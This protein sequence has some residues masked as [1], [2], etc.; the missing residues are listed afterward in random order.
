M[1]KIT[2]ISVFFI[3]V[4]SSQFLHSQSKDK[5]ND[6]NYNF[7]NNNY[8]IAFDLFQKV[9]RKMKMDPVINYR[10]AASLMH[11]NR[12]RSQ[13]IPWLQFVDT[14]KDVPVMSHLYLGEAYFYTMQ[15]DTAKKLI[16]KA[17][18]D[19]G[20]QYDTNEVKKAKLYLKWMGNADKLMK[21]TLNVTFE[22]L[23]ALINTKRNEI[24]PFV[25]GD[26][27]FMVYTTNKK[28]NSDFQV[29]IYNAYFSHPAPSETGYWAKGKSAGSA[30]NTQEDERVVGLS[31]DYE[32]IIVYGDR[33]GSPSDIY[34]AFRSGKRYK[35]LEELGNVVNTKYDEWG[36]SLSKNE[37]TLFFASDRPGGMGGFDIYMSFKLPDGTWGIPQNLGAS[38]NSPYDEVLP[39]V[40]ASGNELTFASNGT[41]SMGNYDIFRTIWLPDARKW[42]KPKNYGYPVNDVYD[43]FTISKTNYRRYAYISRLDSSGYGDMDIEKV[44]FKKVPP[45]MIFR[46]GTVKEG[47]TYQSEDLKHP[48]E[49]QIQIL[50]SKGEEIPS[51][52]KLNETN[53]HYTLALKPGK[54]TLVISGASYR[55]YKKNIVVY[56]EQPIQN[57]IFEDIVIEPKTP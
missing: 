2:Y 27:F 7:E 17:L 10:M 33:I 47:T 8:E 57:I 25:A 29:L 11:I 43:N 28:Y 48:D 6:A 37:D 9:Y 16:N 36:A 55:T 38:V 45:P 52:F 53:H 12:D 35:N 1:K 42:L 39:Q 40:S 19:Y 49:I 41:E 18:K 13:S 44:I 23:G 51:K 31:K 3:L 50:D 34:F 22:N 14:I 4:V 24:F 21:K 54:Y 32:K 46:T 56:D 26:G 5:I 15:F 20:S 30:I